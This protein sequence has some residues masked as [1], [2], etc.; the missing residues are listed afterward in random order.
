MLIQIPLM[1]EKTIFFSLHF[2]YICLKYHVW[3][4][5][6]MLL[7]IE[8]LIQLD[9]LNTIIYFF[10][11]VNHIIYCYERIYRKVWVYVLLN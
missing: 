1:L 5:S 8:I 3:I 4:L 6:E 10:N 7:K 2:I 11:K 9:F